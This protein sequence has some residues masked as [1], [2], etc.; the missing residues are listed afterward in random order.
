M[1]NMN[2]FDNIISEGWHELSGF[3]EV[4]TKI[5]EWGEEV[6]G[7]V[8]R[9]DGKNYLCYEDPS[10]GYRSYSCFDV[11]DKECTNTFPPQRLMVK[12]YAYD[13]HGQD[14]A[15]IAFYNSDLD[16][17]LRVGTDRYDGYY[18]VAVL[19]WHPENLPIN[20]K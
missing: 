18:P 9:V 17:V 20:K 11:T 4:R 10:D 2:E 6:D 19:E 7:L 14:E 5:Y 8:I 3:C 13:K 16:L 1:T 15:G 12:L